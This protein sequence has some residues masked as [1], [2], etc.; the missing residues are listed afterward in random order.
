MFEDPSHQPEPTST[1]PMQTEPGWAETPVFTRLLPFLAAVVIG[2]AGL[3]YAVHEHISAQKLATQNQQVTAQLNT[4]HGQLDALTAKVNALVANDE[5]K[6]AAAAQRE[7]T[8]AKPHAGRR[9]ANVQDLRFKKLQSQVDAQGKEIEDARNDLTSTRTELTGSI[10]K[11][12]DELVVMEKKGQRNFFEFDLQKSKQ[13]QHEGPVGVSLRKANTKHQYAD[14]QLL[15]DDRTLTQKHVNL[16][17]PVMFYQPDSPQPIE[18]VINDISKNHVHG[19][20]SAPKFRNS[21]LAAMANPA[22]GGDQ[23]SGTNTQQA[24]VRQRLPV[25]ASDPVQ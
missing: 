11:T 13:Y 22:Q 21:E 6:A 12:H 17:Q 24:P 16:Y 18:I 9:R 4:T 23:A 10:A 8:E 15:V 7:A 20:I 3:A 14:L 5:A 25:P 19:Y 2:G 1:E